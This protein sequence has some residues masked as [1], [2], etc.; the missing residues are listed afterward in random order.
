MQFSTNIIMI[1]YTLFMHSIFSYMKMLTS[2]RESFVSYK[3]IVTSEV[4]LIISGSKEQCIAKKMKKGKENSLPLYCKEFCH[5]MK[6][7]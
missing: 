4:I 6:N 1:K 2:L 5:Y 3:I 7:L